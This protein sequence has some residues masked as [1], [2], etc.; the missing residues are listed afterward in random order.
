MQS[1]AVLSQQQETRLTEL[2]GTGRNAV[3][4][5][6]KM[7]ANEERENVARKVM[8]TMSVDQLTDLLSFYHT[9]AQICSEVFESKLHGLV[10]HD[11][12]PFH[13]QNH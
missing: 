8:A 1:N 11:I 13:F 3:P 9:M 12:G 6:E 2:G 5:L 10:N 4:Y 7:K